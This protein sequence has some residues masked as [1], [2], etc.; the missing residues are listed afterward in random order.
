MKRVL[1][2]LQLSLGVFQDVLIYVKAAYTA[3]CQPGE[4]V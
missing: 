2:C 1:S 4:G 3:N